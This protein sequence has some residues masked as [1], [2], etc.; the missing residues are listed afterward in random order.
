LLIA[1]MVLLLSEFGIWALALNT[2]T[3]QQQ[4]A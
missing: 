1:F 3:E 4:T 2:H